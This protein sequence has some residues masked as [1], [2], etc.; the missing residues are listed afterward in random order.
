MD[1]PPH[2]V[3]PVLRDAR[4]AGKGIYAMKVLGCGELASDVSRAIGFV[5]E[6]GCVDAL[7]IGPTEDHHLVELVRAVEELWPA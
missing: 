2:E 4:E 7:S 6:T 1:G 3:L 5:A